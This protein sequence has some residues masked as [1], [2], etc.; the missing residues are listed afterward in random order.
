MMK[1]A[2]A[3]NPALTCILILVIWIL[4]LPVHTGE[5]GL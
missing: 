1:I 4:I 3:V 2:P 5:V